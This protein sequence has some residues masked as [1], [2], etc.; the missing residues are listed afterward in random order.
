MFGD[1]V[2][3]SRNSSCDAPVAA[4]M[5]AWPRSVIARR[6]AVAA[7]SAAARPIADLSLNILSSIVKLARPG[8]NRF[9]SVAKDYT[10]GKNDRSDSKACTTKDTKVHEGKP[11]DRKPS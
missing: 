11:E 8:T 4:M 6:I 9:S 5:R 7:W 2:S 10:K 3:A 1:L